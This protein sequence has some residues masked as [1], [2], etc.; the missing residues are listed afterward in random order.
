MEQGHK[1]EVSCLKQHSIMKNFCLLTGSGFED[2]ISGT[3]PLLKL[4]LSIPLPS[5]MIADRK[6]PTSF[7]QEGAI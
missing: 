3:V 7:N 6:N 2:L 4:P 1:N 5:E